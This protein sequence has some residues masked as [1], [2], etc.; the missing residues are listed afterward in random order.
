MRQKLDPP[1]VAR[2]DARCPVDTGNRR[3]QG[4]AGPTGQADARRPRLIDGPN[5]Q[6]RRKSRLAPLIRRGVPT[7]VEAG[8]DVVDDFPA[9]I[10]V[11]PRELDVIEVYLGTLLDDVLGKRDSPEN[12]LSES[13]L[14]CENDGSSARYPT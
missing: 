1:S 3:R 14:R 9:A 7:L 4:V 12:S 10:P 8:P 11:T 2:S 5:A 13:P 6:P